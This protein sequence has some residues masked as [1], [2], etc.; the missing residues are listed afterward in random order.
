MLPLRHELHDILRRLT[1][2]VFPAGASS[3][4]LF[5]LRHSKGSRSAAALCLFFSEPSAAPS[6]LLPATIVCFVKSRLLCCLSRKLH[7]QEFKYKNCQ[8]NLQKKE[9][10]SD[11]FSAGLR[12][13]WT[14]QHQ[15]KSEGFGSY[16][17]G[18]SCDNNRKRLLAWNERQQQ[19]GQLDQN[20]TTF[21]Q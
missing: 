19:R 11:W 4:T 6:S 1:G 20:R 10:Q 9:V 5:I 13:D 15:I 18:F 7:W 12:Y 3:P 17:P 14:S 21:P 2:S 16:S 8:V